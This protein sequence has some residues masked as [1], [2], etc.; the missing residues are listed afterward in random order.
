MLRAFL[1]NRIHREA[2]E[3]RAEFVLRRQEKVEEIMERIDVAATIAA[4]A[5]TCT[6][7]FGVLIYLFIQAFAAPVD[8]NPIESGYSDEE[9]VIEWQFP[10]ED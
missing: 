7:L 2:N 8:G 5:I 9:A 10:W 4:I 6:L 1:R 3:S